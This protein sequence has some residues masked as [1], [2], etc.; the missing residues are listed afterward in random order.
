VLAV[1]QIA[2]C[3]T[4]TAALQSSQPTMALLS[5]HST[6]TQQLNMLAELVRGSLPS[7]L[8]RDVLMA[9]ITL[10][11]H[12]RDIVKDTLIQDR[13]Q[14]ETDFAWMQQ[15]RAWWWWAAMRLCA[16]VCVE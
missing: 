6:I 14:S 13:V 11:V 12:A 8:Q 2:W 7:Q 1:A 9:L 3:R 16:C 15:V 10:D 4:V 5:Y